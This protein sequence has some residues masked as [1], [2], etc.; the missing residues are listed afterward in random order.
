MGVLENKVY[1]VSKECE[2]VEMLANMLLSNAATFCKGNG[3]AGAE[4]D[5]N[6]NASKAALLNQIT[7]LRNELLVL[8]EDIKAC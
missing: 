5:K 4:Y 6:H 3:R 8:K 1:K 2:K 7:T